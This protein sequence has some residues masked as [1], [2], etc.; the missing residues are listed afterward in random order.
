MATERTIRDED[1]GTDERA[2]QKLTRSV[3]TPLVRVKPSRGKLFGRRR[4]RR[5]AGS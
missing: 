1:G 3:G 5:A 2:Q 4:E